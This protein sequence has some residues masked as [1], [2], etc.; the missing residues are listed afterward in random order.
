MPFQRVLAQKYGLKACIKSLPL[1]RNV[2][3]KQ[4]GRQRRAM[5]L[6]FTASFRLG[7]L[8]V[9]PS[10]QKQLDRMQMVGF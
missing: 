8:S 1:I 7:L 3:G 4:R 6:C 10:T 2:L 9:P 5:V